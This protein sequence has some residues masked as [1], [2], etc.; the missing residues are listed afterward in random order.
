[1]EGFYLQQN[2]YIFSIQRSSSGEGNHIGNSCLWLRAQLCAGPHEVIVQRQNACIYH[3]GL[4]AEEVGHRKLP[5]LRG[6][7]CT[8]LTRR[9]SYCFPKWGRK[10]IGER[11]LCNRAHY[12]VDKV[13]YPY[14]ASS[15]NIWACP[16]LYRPK[17]AWWKKR[18][19]LPT[20]EDIT[21]ELIVQH[22]SPD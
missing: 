10:C 20:L 9:H 8:Y 15:A 11:G 3:L 6:T 4:H 22:S 1:M 13:V 21:S 5:D 2:Q 18:Y 16:S 17:E 7:L 14:D 19:I 12:W